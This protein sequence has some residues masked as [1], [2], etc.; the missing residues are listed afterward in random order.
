MDA[1]INGLVAIGTLA[2]AVLAIWGER[3]RSI[4]A[5]PL[6]VLEPHNSAGDPTEL[7]AQGAP[8]GAG[9]RVLYYHLKVVNKRPWLPVANCSVFLRG[10][11]R[12]GPDG[13][14]H[15][16]HMPV[17]LQYVWAPAEVTP[18]SIT[19]TK[20]HVLDFGSI[21]EGQD[22]FRPQLYSYS[23]NFQGFVRKDEALRYQLEVQGSNFSSRRY[24]VFEVAWDG[25]WSYIPS[26]MQ[27]HLRIREIEP[28]QAAAPDGGRGAPGHVECAVTGR[29]G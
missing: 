15:P 28:S 23:N 8:P 22:H 16:V 9:I 4:L 17:P 12:R 13:I 10:I 5:P 24:Q 27:Q 21:I 14:F 6:L 20:E 19:V 3:I 1:I 29:R 11:F 26:E 25:T 2:V 7:R 18:P